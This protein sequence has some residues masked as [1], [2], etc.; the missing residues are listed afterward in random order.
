[1]FLSCGHF[2]AR[3]LTLMWRGLW[4]WHWLHMQIPFRLPICCLQLAVSQQ[5]YFP[6]MISTLYGF[7]KFCNCAPRNHSLLA[8]YIKFIQN[9]KYSTTH[10]PT[11]KCLYA[12]SYYKNTTT[13]QP[14]NLYEV[15][16]LWDHPTAL[17]WQVASKCSSIIILHAVTCLNVWKSA[18]ISLPW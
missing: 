9:C 10:A 7:S 18:E 15:E 11:Q 4:S 8:I 17:P 1:M 5:Q 3:H 2:I 14:S 12:H 13:R 16:Y 6:S